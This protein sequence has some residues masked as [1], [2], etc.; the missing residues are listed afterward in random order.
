MSDTLIM[1][2]LIYALDLLLRFLLV[3]SL[4][5]STA[6][7][8]V[9]FGYMSIS[10]VIMAYNRITGRIIGICS[11]CLKIPESNKPVVYFKSV[12]AYFCLECFG[13]A[14]DEVLG[15]PKLFERCPKCDLP[16]GK[17]LGKP[18]VIKSKGLTVDSTG[19][20]EE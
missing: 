18:M 19:K 13:E 20:A 10:I 3:L 9:L 5:L 2:M 15:K 7:F 12:N 6:F 17:H 16:L 8:V 1:E 11:A 4:V 14:A